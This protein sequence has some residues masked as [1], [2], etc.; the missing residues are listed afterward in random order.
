MWVRTLFESSIISVLVNGSPTDEFS[1]KRGLRQGDPLSPLLFNLV[2]EVLSKLLNEANKWKIFTGIKFSGCDKE[3]THLQYAD[4]VIIF[5]DNEKSSIKGIK[6]VL[7][8][9]E[10]LSG[11]HINFNKSCLFG[12]GDDHERMA[13]WASMLGCEIGVDN[14]LHL[15]TEIGISPA[16]VKYWDPLVHKLKS[17]LQEWNTNYISMAGRLVL[18]KASI[19]SL[20]IFWFNL[21]SIPSTVLNR[22]EQIR[23]NFLWGHALQEKKKIHL[24]KLESCLFT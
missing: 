13:K 24:F 22:M 20:P 16:S 17:R 14:L 2:G 10:L 19:D 11:L 1:L 18:L 21:F 7:Q 12:F 9:F 4:D 23:R 6:E 5:I 3:L 15:S 8:C